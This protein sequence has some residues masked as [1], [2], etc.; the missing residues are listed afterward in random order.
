MAA[1]F[2]AIP[3]SVCRCGVES[4]P[5]CRRAYHVRCIFWDCQSNCWQL[6]GS[7][8]LK[9]WLPLLQSQGATHLLYQVKDMYLRPQRSYPIGEYFRKVA[10]GRLLQYYHS[11][12][13][14]PFPAVC[15]QAA[16]RSI[17]NEVF[18]LYNFLNQ[19]LL[20]MIKNCNSMCKIDRKHGNFGHKTP[21]E[22][23]CNITIWLSGNNYF[24]HYTARHFHNMSHRE[25]VI[26]KYLK[27][28]SS[29]RK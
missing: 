21:N 6:P 5:W 13:C 3:R 9:R 22:G 28:Y 16:I 2:Q 17:M 25:S 23:V 7:G 15:V 18:Y 20:D 19:S 27:K 11:V 24:A 8:C 26:T 29:A 14:S 1:D 4:I 12:N 10:V